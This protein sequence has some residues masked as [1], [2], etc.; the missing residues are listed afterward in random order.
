MLNVYHEAKRRCNYNA[1]YFLQLVSNE[2]GLK[3]A[4]KLLMTAPTTGFTTLQEYGCLDISAEAQI[5]KPEYATL[6]TDA[7]RD[8]ARQRLA[9]YGYQFNEDTN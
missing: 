2:G 4:K 9:E 3:A 8:L 1:T 7:E 6:F 5:I